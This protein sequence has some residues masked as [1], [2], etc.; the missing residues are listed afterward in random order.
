MNELG[1]ITVK[2]KITAFFLVFVTAIAV[3]KVW[4]PTEAFSSTGPASEVKVFLD[5]EPLVFEVQPQIVNDRAFVPLR[6]I[7]EAMGASVQWDSVMNTAITLKDNTV[8]ILTIGDLNPTINGHIVNIDQPGYIVDGR[9]LAPLRFV[10]E[11]YGG[12][13]RWDP[14]ART[15]SIY[16]EG[17]EPPPIQPIVPPAPDNGA[18]DFSQIA[19][20]GIAYPKMQMI[21]KSVRDIAD[22][23]KDW[24]YVDSNSGAVYYE[25]PKNKATLAIAAGSTGST[26]EQGKNLTGDEI[27]IGVVDEMGHF[28]PGAEWPKSVSETTSFLGEYLGLDFEMLTG[29][30]GGFRYQIK[31]R[32]NNYNISIYTDTGL[33]TNK[34]S[35]TIF[36]IR[37]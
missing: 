28:F 7:Y 19:R 29:E 12:T 15:A 35:I 21:G 5:G 24:K 31:L 2:W 27:C 37:K 22:N 1:E 33:I 10:A 23:Y 14:V 32:Q 25:N 9:I 4:A 13:V 3:S 26:E 11:A 20:W 18:I 8:V 17:V 6:A 36:R 16:S 30:A 34:T